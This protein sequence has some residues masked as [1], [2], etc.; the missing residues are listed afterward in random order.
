MD[1]QKTISYTEQKRQAEDH[2]LLEILH[3][4][5]SQGDKNVL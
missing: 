3:Y 4:S 5:H 1:A 2:Y